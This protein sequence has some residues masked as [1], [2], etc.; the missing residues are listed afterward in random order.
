M[1]EIFKQEETKK[2]VLTGKNV[3][4][5]VVVNCT[6]GLRHEGPDG[7]TES[8]HLRWEYEKRYRIGLQSCRVL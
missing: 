4:A 6:M 2:Y 8:T 1:E 5:L 3:F 7:K